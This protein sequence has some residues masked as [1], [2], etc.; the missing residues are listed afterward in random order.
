MA[1]EIIYRGEMCEGQVR[2]EVSLDDRTVTVTYIDGDISTSTIRYS[3]QERQ[4]VY[5]LTN[6]TDL[7][8]PLDPVLGKNPSETDIT[9]TEFRT[10]REARLGLIELI[11]APHLE[12]T[13]CGMPFDV[14]AVRTELRISLG[15]A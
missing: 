10:E 13:E 8:T 1:K 5:F 2:T 12:K 7:S 6:V 11:V 3:Y 9:Q 14:D 4:G 15:V